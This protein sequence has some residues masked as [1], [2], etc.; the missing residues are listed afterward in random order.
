MVGPRPVHGA[1][2][3]AELDRLGLSPDEV[4]DFSASINPLG[5]AP[6]VLRA[7]RAADA[8]TY[9]DPD[10]R[11]LRRALSLKLGVSP[12][13]IL[14]GNGSTEL[15]HLLARALLQ[16]GDR[17]VVFAPGFGEYAAACRLQRV[18]PRR[19]HPEKGKGFRWDLKRAAALI[20]EWRPALTFLGNPNNPTGVYLERQEVNAVAEAIGSAGLLVLDEAYA[21][22]VDR[23]WRS[24]SLLDKSDAVLLRSMTKDHAIPGLRLG[25]MLASTSVIEKTRRFQFS[26]SVNSLAQAAGLAALDQ[27]GHVSQA[28][29]VVRASREYLLGALRELGLACNEPSA[30]FLLIE[31]G[32]AP[33]VR[34]ELLRRYRLCVRDCTSFGMPRH[35]RVGIRGM[36]DCR[37]LVRALKEIYPV[38]LD[39][40]SG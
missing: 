33:A 9:P 32:D 12:D 16:A 4:I 20:K 34:F 22:F 5:P 2:S 18:E 17:V 29:R 19:I 35:I 40:G 30:N 28:R 3:A 1:V 37:R 14:V 6:G 25:Y 15:I 11:R 38:R 13:N 27:S 26:W 8:S 36:D 39:L 31:V 7:I 21:A 24:R 23:P 10:C